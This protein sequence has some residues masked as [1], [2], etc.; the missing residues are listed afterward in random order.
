MACPAPGART[1]GTEREEFWSQEA[2]KKGT[3]F[4]SRGRRLAF[5]VYFLHVNRLRQIQARDAGRPEPHHCETSLSFENL[6]SRQPVF[7][8]L[9]IGG[10]CSFVP[11]GLLLRHKEVLGL[12]LLQDVGGWP[13]HQVDWGAP[14]PSGTRMSPQG[15]GA[16]ASLGAL[17]VFPFRC[18]TGTTQREREG[19]ESP[20]GAQILQLRWVCRLNGQR[21]WFSRA[22]VLSCHLPVRH[23][24]HRDR[25]HVQS[26]CDPDGLALPPARVPGQ[27]TPVPGRS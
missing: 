19:R 15:E 16:S 13:G 2:G 12:T 18:S 21:R 10:G 25:E 5:V 4:V 26:L 8:F 17:A 24:D 3:C 22:F 6:K 20:G 7:H 11:P 27:I 1:E 23:V 14:G 9:V